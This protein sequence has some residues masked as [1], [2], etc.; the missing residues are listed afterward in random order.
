MLAWGVMFWRHGVTNLFLFWLPLANI[1]ALVLSTYMDYD[2][3]SMISQVEGL[4]DLKYACK[5]A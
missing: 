3:K 4:E 1:T 5:A 2:C